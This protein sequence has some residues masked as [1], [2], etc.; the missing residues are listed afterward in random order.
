MKKLYAVHGGENI[1]SI[2]K[3]DFKEEAF[4]VFASHQ[5]EDEIFKEHISEFVV[6]NSLL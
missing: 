6:N 4:D 2:V 5:M 3:A 1:Y